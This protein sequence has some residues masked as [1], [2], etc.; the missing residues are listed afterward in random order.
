[1]LACK[2]EFTD[3]ALKTLKKM[4]RHTAAMIIGYTEKK[5]TGDIDPRVLGKPLVGN[6]QEKWQ[7]RIGSYRLLCEIE[8]ERVTLIVIQIG[9]RNDVYGR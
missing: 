5:L 1:M 7:Y 3:I 8:D 9:K 6:H 2:V 4:D